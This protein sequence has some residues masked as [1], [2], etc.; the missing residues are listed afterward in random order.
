MALQQAQCAGTGRQEEERLMAQTLG[1][2]ACLEF[3]L[4]L[5]HRGG[6]IAL[7]CFKSGVTA[8]MKGDGSLVTAVERDI[9]K[10]LRDTIR[11]GYPSDAVLG[12][13]LGELPGASG[14]R[15]L[16]DPID[17]TASFVRGI[18]FFGVMIALEDNGV[19]VLGTVH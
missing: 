11:A 10:L 3:S 18:P 4:E 6:E 12:E 5:A 1:L 14:R 17:G 16:V 13:E 2:T 15:W 7:E 9:E 8:E 19:P